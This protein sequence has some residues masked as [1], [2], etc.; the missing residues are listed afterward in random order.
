MMKLRTDIRLRKIGEEYIIVD[1]GQGMADMSKVYTLNETAAFVWNEL[2][3]LEFSDAT[4][5]ELLLD[6]YDLT[7]ETA[8]ED[9]KNLIRNLQDEGLLMEI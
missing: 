5:V 9:A 4:I 2:K 3:D 6:N 1:P 8:Q 7:P